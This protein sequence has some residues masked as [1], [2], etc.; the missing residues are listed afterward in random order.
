MYVFP[1][2]QGSYIFQSGRA[3]LQ[4]FRCPVY[5]NKFNYF[6]F[7]CYAREKAFCNFFIKEVTEKD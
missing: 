3:F 6:L 2:K 4:G 7:H 5:L 1:L